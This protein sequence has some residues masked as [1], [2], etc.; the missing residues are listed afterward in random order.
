MIRSNLTTLVLAV[1][2]CLSLAEPGGSYILTGNEKS[3]DEIVKHD[4]EKYPDLYIGESFN[5]YVARFKKENE[6]GKRKLAPDD[7]LTF[8]ETRASIKAKKAAQKQRLIG[9]WQTEHDHESWVECHVVDYREDGTLK[10]QMTIRSTKPKFKV[11]YSGKWEVEDG[12]LKVKITESSLPQ[13]F[14]TKTLEPRMIIEI[15]DTELT[16]QLKKRKH[17][18]VATRVK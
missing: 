7:A 3:V 17:V 4:M 12:Y 10:G 16:I 15:T 1:T 5:F 13:A 6:I 11:D 9:K 8:P 18:I 2:T 14:S